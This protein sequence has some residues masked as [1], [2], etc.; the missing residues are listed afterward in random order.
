MK[1]PWR[2]IFGLVLGLVLGLSIFIGF[3]YTQLGVPTHMSQWISDISQKKERLAAQVQGPRLLIVGGSS[4]LFSFNAAMIEKE[5]GIPTI[6]LG[7]HAG[8]CLD[9]R[10]YRIEKVARPGDI[11]LL[12]CEY[13]F[14][15]NG[16]A[17]YSENNDDY[18]LARDPDYFHHMPL[19]SK[20]DMATRIAFKRLQKGWSDR[21]KPEVI[22]PPTSPPYSVYTPIT[23]GIDCLDDNGDEVFNVESAKPPWKAESFDRLIPELVDGLPSDS[24]DG[25]GV[26]SAFLDWAK[27]HH[28]KVLATFPA[29]VYQP[30]Y[31]GPNGRKAVETINRFYTS[32]CVPVI[33][34]AREMMLP[35]EQFF[36]TMYHLTHEAALNRTARF[37]PELKPYLPPREPSA[38]K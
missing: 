2:F 38:S 11:V 31:V 33:G 12:A 9:Y 26:L 28:I 35:I 22:E 32:H 18:V 6:N 16:F 36:D 1:I 34:N 14:Y 8:L 21:R 23:P 29:A 3:L 27:A 7:T 15:A 5:T 13:E 24:T 10:L 20:I 19:P 25:F 17:A 37:I 30:E 4:A